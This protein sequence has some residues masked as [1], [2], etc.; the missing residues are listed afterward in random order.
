VSLEVLTD[1]NAKLRLHRPPAAT[2]ATKVASSAT[3]AASVTAVTA[4][5]PPPTYDD[6][7]AGAPALLRV[8]SAPTLRPPST[9]VL[10]RVVAFS[11]DGAATPMLT[12][13]DEASMATPS[14]QTPL[15]MV[16]AR[17]SLHQTP[18]SVV[19]AKSVRRLS[20]SS[21]SAPGPEVPATPAP[22]HALALS[23]APAA[24]AA[25][26]A[27][28]VA[29]VVA[30][31]AV[32]GA[33]T[34]ISTTATATTTTAV[35][36]TA[37]RPIQVLTATV[38]TRPGGAVAPTMVASVGG[39]ASPPASSLSSSPPSS[40][41][42]LDSLSP[43]TAAA[44][45]EAAGLPFGTSDGT[46]AG[47]GGSFT[48]VTDS[49]RA[50][51]RLQAVLRGE[52]RAA[53]DAA[54]ARHSAGH[55]GDPFGDNPL[56]LLHASAVYQRGL[57]HLLEELNRPTVP[58]RLSLS[59]QLRLPAHPWPHTRPSSPIATCSPRLVTAGCK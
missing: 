16:V 17:Q 33:A 8:A 22:L 25:P 48:P 37:P 11:A 14:G 9:P 38:S 6:A 36:T 19:V 43:R 18:L 51:V 52:E 59:A 27:R 46:G 31:K 47:K 50:I 7:V 54:V 44:V 53:F 32:A 28:A 41:P 20:L 21:P 29:T 2:P 3:T 40:L 5:P 15:A 4:L 55:S 23:A 42:S 58:V 26:Q 56:P 49:L 1:P 45:A 39:R 24:P 10:P 13:T 34:A 57:C 35:A 12:P 30:D